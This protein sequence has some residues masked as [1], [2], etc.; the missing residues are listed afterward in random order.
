MPAPTMYAQGDILIERVRRKRLKSWSDE[1]PA[2][3]DGTIVLER[4]EF[5]GHRHAVHGDARF[6]REYPLGRLVT[7]YVGH[8]HVTGDGVV[9]R[10]EEHDPIPLPKGIYRVHRQREFT[11][12]ESDLGFVAD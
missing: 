2:E 3:P 10:H 12:R 4:G 11:A 1:I 6:V 9:L 5:S 8:L 7:N